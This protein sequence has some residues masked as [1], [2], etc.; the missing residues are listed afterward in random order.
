MIRIQ[1][2]RIVSALISVG[3][4]LIFPLEYLICFCLRRKTVSIMHWSFS[5]AE[6]CYMEPRTFQ[7]LSFCCPDSEVLGGNRTGTAD[8]V[9]PKGYF[10][11]I[12]HHAKEKKRKGKK[13]KK[14]LKNS[15]ELVVWV[16][17]AWGLPGYQPTSGEELLVHLLV[18]ICT[19]IYVYNCYLYS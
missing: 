11:K 3:T 7:L 1:G 15:G 17:I 8:L 12:W 9:W 16:A 5:C 6:K 14:T 10:I 18:Y 19:Y 2:C 13:K 4:E